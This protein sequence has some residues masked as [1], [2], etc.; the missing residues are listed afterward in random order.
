MKKNGQAGFSRAR[1][2]KELEACLNLVNGQRKQ[3]QEPPDVSLLFGQENLLGWMLNLLKT[4]E[5]PENLYGLPYLR[6][7]YEEFME[8][9]PRN[10]N[11]KICFPRD[12]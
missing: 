8:G 3:Q 9:K 6:R 4:A 1:C 5:L 2:R 12:G 10:S 11:A 7:A